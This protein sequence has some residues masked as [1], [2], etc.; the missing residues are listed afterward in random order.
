MGKLPHQASSAV[1]VGAV[2][3]PR[4]NYFQHSDTPHLP[5]NQTSRQNLRNGRQRQ[6]DPDGVRARAPHQLCR[7][8]SADRS[9]AL[10]QRCPH[11]PTRHPIRAVRGQGRG[12]RDVPRRGRADDE[13]VPRD[14]RVSRHVRMAAVGL[15]R[16]LPRWRWTPFPCR[17]AK[18][19]TRRL[20]S[21]RPT[22][23]TED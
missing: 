11:Q 21:R 20:R 7:S 16:A 6:R 15:R 8:S 13:Q 14:D 12:L 17:K 18:I 2:E 22:S 10:Q 9:C 1:G 4:L 19:Q 3:P 23:R 5:A